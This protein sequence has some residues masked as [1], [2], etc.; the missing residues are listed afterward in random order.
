MICKTPACISRAGISG[1]CNRCAQHGLLAL[2]SESLME[3]AP[4]PE[5]PDI[6]PRRLPMCLCCPQHDHLTPDGLC[7]TCAVEFAAARELMPFSLY[8]WRLWRSA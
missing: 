6:Q 3:D 2:R 5:P 7:S 4:P 1:Y 8:E